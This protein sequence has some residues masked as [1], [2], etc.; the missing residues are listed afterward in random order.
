LKL[1]ESMRNNSRTCKAYKKEWLNEHM[2]DI[3]VA[4]LGKEKGLK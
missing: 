2:K 1:E 4:K 3:Y